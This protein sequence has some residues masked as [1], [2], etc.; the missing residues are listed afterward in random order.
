MKVIQAGDRAD[1]GQS[2]DQLSLI[3]ATFETA[4]TNCPP[5]TAP[6]Q[7]VISEKRGNF[8][9]LQVVSTFKIPVCD[10]SNLSAPCD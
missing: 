1:A 10:E 4:I 8:I 3:R 7:R 2:S 9:Y 6:R 5:Q